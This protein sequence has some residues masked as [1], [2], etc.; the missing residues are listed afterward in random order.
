MKQEALAI[1]D[2]VSLPECWPSSGL[3]E[4]ERVSARYAPDLNRVL[5]EVTFTMKPLKR[6]GI[7]G[8]TGAGKSSF[9]LTL[10]RGL[11]IESRRIR[12]NGVDTRDIGLH[13]LRRRLAV[14]PQD[15]TLRGHFTF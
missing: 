2:T 11:E 13:E 14:V 1:M 5:R 4:Y 7:L 6:V 8:R 15:P 10:L 3:V 12:I 9:V